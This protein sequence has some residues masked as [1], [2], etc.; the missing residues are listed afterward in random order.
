MRNKGTMGNARLQSGEV[1]S[2]LIDLHS[3]FSLCGPG[4]YPVWHAA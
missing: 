3:F 2:N 4:N 1:L